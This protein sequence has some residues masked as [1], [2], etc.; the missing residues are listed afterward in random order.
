S[1]ESSSLEAQLSSL[2]TRTRNNSQYRGFDIAVAGLLPHDTAELADVYI[3]EKPYS[4]PTTF[5]IG[6]SV[7]DK[8]VPHVLPGLMAGIAVT[9]FFGFWGGAQYLLSEKAKPLEARYALYTQKGG[10]SV[11]MDN[12]AG[13]EAHMQAYASNFGE[14]VAWLAAISSV[15]GDFEI[16][17]IEFVRPSYDSDLWLKRK[18]RTEMVIT[19]QVAMSDEERMKTSQSIISTL[20]ASVQRNVILERKSTRKFNDTDYKIEVAIKRAP[21]EDMS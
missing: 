19:L 9:G 18:D 14:H 17:R 7:R 8:I 16:T 4:R 12:I 11:S 20:A 2:V 6:V 3:G 13:K 1:Y 21:Q 10:P 5:Q 15:P